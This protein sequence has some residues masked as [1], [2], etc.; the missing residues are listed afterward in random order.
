MPP[1]PVRIV[2]DRRASTLFTI[3]ACGDRQSNYLRLEH[4][5]GLRLAM[6]IGVHVRDCEASSI[7]SSTALPGVAP[8][9]FKLTLYPKI[10][11]DERVTISLHRY[12]GD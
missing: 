4:V 8:L 5:Y 10:E 2:S 7:T 1:R 6:A 3:L 11:K 12:Q 9:S